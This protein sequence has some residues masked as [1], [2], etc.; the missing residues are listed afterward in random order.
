MRA[1]P[2][3]CHHPLAEIAAR[4]ARARGLELGKLASLEKLQLNGNRFSGALP[5]EI[6]R[7][8]ARGH[9]VILSANNPGFTLP[10][11]VDELGYEF[12]ELDLMNCSLRGKLPP[13][14]GDLIQVG[15]TGLYVKKT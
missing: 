5:I 6:L 8:K 12:E 3:C 11:D 13:E 7:M 4:Q 9:K 14:I 1:S 15:R 10:H 2:R